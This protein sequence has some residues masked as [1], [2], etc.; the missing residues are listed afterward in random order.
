MKL[1]KTTNLKQAMLV[2][3]IIVMIS[4][5]NDDDTSNPNNSINVQDFISMTFDENPETGQSIGTINATSN[6]P[7]AFSILE[8]AFT[9]A[10]VVNPNTGELTVGDASF[11]D[12]ETNPAIQS[13]IEINNGVE[14]IS[15]D[16]RIDLNNR[17]DIAFVLTNSQQ[18]YMD[19]QAGDWIEIT[20]DEYERLNQVLIDVLKAGF[21]EDVTTINPSSNG[22]FTMANLDESTRNMNIM[23]NNSLVFA[24]RY[25]AVDNQLN[26]DRHRVK[27]SSLANS[28]GFENI[29]NPLPPHQREN[30]AACFVLKGSEALIT[31]EQGFL[32]FQKSSGS[33]M[34]I[35][36][37]SGVML[38]AQGEASEFNMESNGNLALY[39]GLSTTIKQWD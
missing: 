3:S 27:Q 31:S 39:E 25:Y 10:I 7:L 17:D 37:T 29:G 24:F 15:V 5:G 11:F 4:C 23:P 12:F 16:L 8:Q 14:T 2:F 32:G 33:T 9:N 35:A 38:F 13:V 34:G 20:A 18:N 26:S 30:G 1:S 6:L 19:A 21:F 36:I 28:I 22:V